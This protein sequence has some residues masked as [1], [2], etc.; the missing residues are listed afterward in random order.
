MYN[1]TYSFSDKSIESLIKIDS[2]KEKWKLC[3]E[4]CSSCFYRCTKILGHLKE[5]DCGF[6]HVCHEKCQICDEIKCK[7]FDNCNHFCYDQK[8]GHPEKHKC[9]HFHKCQGEY[10]NKGLRE[11][12]IQCKLEYNHE[13]PCNCKSSH[14]CKKYCIYYKSSKNCKG[15]CNLE[16][17]H[18]G[19]CKSENETHKR[20]CR[21]KGKSLGYINDGKCDFNLPHAEE[22]CNYR[23]NHK[24][25]QICSLFGLS[26]G[27]NMLCLHNCGHKGDNEE[28]LCSGFHKCIETCELNGKDNKCNEE[29]SLPYGP[30]ITTKIIIQILAILSIAD[31]IWIIFFSGHG[32]I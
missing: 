20:D 15:K 6:D 31:I 24:C 14:L 25:I 21:Y 18:Q 27:C 19:D 26:K 3:H 5:H 2:L 30:K 4:K 8:S 9:K 12:K 11:C 28:H 1:L 17:N 32:H 23:G 7:D 13:S 22:N 10:S 16:S 29:C